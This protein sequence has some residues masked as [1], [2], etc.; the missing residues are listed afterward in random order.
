MVNEQLISGPVGREKSCGFVFAV[1]L[2][3][4]SGLVP[5]ELF[6]LRE[7]QTLDVLFGQ[8]LHADFFRLCLSGLELGL[9]VR[10]R[11]HVVLALDRCPTRR[12][13]PHEM[14]VGRRRNIGPSV[15]IA[16]VGR[17]RSDDRRRRCRR[18]AYRRAGRHIADGRRQRCVH[19]RCRGRI[20]DRRRRRRD[21]L[22]RCAA[23]KQSH[24]GSCR[25][26]DSKS[27]AHAT[28][29]LGARFANHRLC[30]MGYQKVTRRGPGR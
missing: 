28:G 25:G 18:I 13:P 8:V 11:R 22:P 17:R 30:P 20:G 16:V 23:R 9:R 6:D 10:L 29:S 7:A 15:G 4:A 24:S 19:N 1:A 5:P 14:W 2:P 26:R 12:G 3:N 27:F 21:R